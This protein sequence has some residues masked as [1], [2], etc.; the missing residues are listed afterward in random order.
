M[1]GKAIP[2]LLMIVLVALVST[3]P[4]KAQDEELQTRADAALA[5]SDSGDH[6]KSYRLWKELFDLGPARLGNEG[7]SFARA[8]VYYEAMT[9]IAEIGDGKCASTIEWAQRGRSVGAPDYKH[10]YDVLYW[11]LLMADAVC[12]ADQKRH[13]EAYSEL[14][15]AQSELRKAPAG[16]AADFLQSAAEYLAAVRPSVMKEGDYVTNT[17]VLQ[18]W[19]GKVVGRSADA[20]EIRLTYVNSAL[21]SSLVKGQ[22]RSLAVSE[23]APLGAVSADAVLKGWRD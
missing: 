19:I 23:C 18:R 10:E 7:Y 17:G 20:L 2:G 8:H 11:A 21:T 4:L 1:K 14:L 22:T 15:L 9:R 16:Q 12:D 13:E 5:A 3:L 6:E